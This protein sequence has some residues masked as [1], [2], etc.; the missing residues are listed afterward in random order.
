MDVVQV[1]VQDLVDFGL[2]PYSGWNWEVARDP[3]TRPALVKWSVELRNIT[4][5]W[6]VYVFVHVCVH[7]FICSSKP[8]GILRNIS[9]AGEAARGYMRQVLST[10]SANSLLSQNPNLKRSHLCVVY[11]SKVWWTLSFG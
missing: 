1:C 10:S 6:C 11:R 8:S 9:S 2:I 5:G 4:G 7:I 3:F